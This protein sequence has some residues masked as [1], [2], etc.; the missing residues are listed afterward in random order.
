MFDK[1]KGLY[2]LQKK[3]RQIQSDLKKMEFT[4]EA[5]GGEIVVVMNGLQDILRIEISEET[6]N[7]L[8][9]EALG[10]GIAEAANKAKEKSQKHA[11][12]MMREVGGGLGLPGM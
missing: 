3:A 12:A 10:K 1:V 11:A 2:Q 6:K 4:G 9:V 8:T 5:R 7:E